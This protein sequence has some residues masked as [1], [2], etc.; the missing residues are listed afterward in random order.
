M[1]WVETVWV[2]LLE[3]ALFFWARLW[4]GP[5]AAEALR[6]LMGEDETCVPMG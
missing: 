6:E 4:G 2:W 1:S 5:D 3:Q